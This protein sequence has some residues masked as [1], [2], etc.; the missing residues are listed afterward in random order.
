MHRKTKRSRRRIRY[1]VALIVRVKTKTDGTALW[2]ERI[3]IF[4]A[5][6]NHKKKLDF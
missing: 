2:E 5:Y 6:E 1:D 3:S 4:R